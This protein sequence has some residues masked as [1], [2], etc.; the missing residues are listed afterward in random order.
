MSATTCDDSIRIRVNKKL[1][2]EASEVLNAMGL[3][4]SD[5]FRISLIKLVN[6]KRIPFAV[7]M[8]NQKTVEAMEMVE[9]GEV[10][11]HSSVSEYFKNRGR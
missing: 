10:T 11:R 5:F 3:N 4:F 1:K 7:E 8:P 2:A 6:E 9:R